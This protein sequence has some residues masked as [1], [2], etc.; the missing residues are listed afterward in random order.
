MHRFVEP[1]RMTL[2]NIN[3]GPSP[4]D[5]LQEPNGVVSGELQERCR[6]RFEVRLRRRDA[7]QVAHTALTRFG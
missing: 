2:I 6:R 4:Q 5:E 1:V 3:R 7:L